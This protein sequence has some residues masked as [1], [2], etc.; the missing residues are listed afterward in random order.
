MIDESEREFQGLA[1]A[2]PKSPAAKE[3]LASIRSLR[4]R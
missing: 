1:K 2:N 3:L 4:H